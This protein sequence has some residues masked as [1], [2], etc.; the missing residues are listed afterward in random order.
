MAKSDI[1]INKICEFCGKN[2]VAQKAT[3]RY[4]SHECNAKAYKV[5]KRNSVKENAEKNSF[6]NQTRKSTQNIKEKEF[7]TVS[8][9]G[10]FLG[11]SRFTIYNMIRSGKI[12][13][14][15]LSSRLTLIR[16]KDLDDIFDNAPEYKALP[17]RIDVESEIT[18]FYTLA[19][20]KEKFGLKETWIYKIVREKNI[21]KVLKRGKTYFSKKHI[22]RH[23]PKNSGDPTI[24]EWY[25]V[26]D[27]Q[28]KYYLTLAA[29]YS[30]V[31]ENNIPKRKEGRK[32]FYSKKHFEVAKGYSEQEE[33]EYYTIEE[34]IA[35]FNVTRDVLYYYTKTYNL[36]KVKVG[37][38]IKISKKEL[39][40]IFDN[41]KI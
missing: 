16:K 38:Y 19:E 8:E 22:D 24:T 39:D 13:A 41:P 33:P 2:F 17:Q 15:Q 21:P 1:K 34:A 23:F 25:S 3:T 9:T 28:K 14:V 37:K 27:I 31:S 4:C 6:I 29:I 32:V 5:N 30:F 12:K 18:E 26:E 35:K 7:L 10:A 20:I 11:L 36:L 40:K